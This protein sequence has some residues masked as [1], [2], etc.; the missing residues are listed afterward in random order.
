MDL[1]FWINIKGPYHV[2]L[3]DKNY[4]LNLALSNYFLESDLAGI[5]TAHELLGNNGHEYVANGGASVPS[6]A[7]TW[8]R[9]LSYVTDAT[10]ILINL[11]ILTTAY[12]VYTAPCS[13]LPCLHF[14]KVG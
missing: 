12:N 5:L 9:P 3:G 14:D 8:P 10:R 2:L 1:S 4:S 11:Y 7:L 6:P 13:D